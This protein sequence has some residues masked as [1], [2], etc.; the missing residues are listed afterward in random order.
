MTG[1]IGVRASMRPPE[2][3]GGNGYNLQHC[4][5]Q[6]FYCFNEAAGIH[7]RKRPGRISQ[8]GG[9]FRASMRPPEFTGGNYQLLL[10]C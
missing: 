1:A 2:F 4:T 10:Q 9:R 6:F 3:T 5:D 8:G 7:R